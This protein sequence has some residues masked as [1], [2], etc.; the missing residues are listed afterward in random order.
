MLA[1][2]TAI[3]ILNI[4]PDW[5]VWMALTA[6]SFWDIVAV[7]TPCGPLK[8]LV[9][10][11]NRRGD[12]KFP[13]ILYNCK[14]HNKSPKYKKTIKAKTTVPGLIKNFKKSTSLV[15]RPTQK[16]QRVPLKCRFIFFFEKLNNFSKFIREWSGFPWHNTIK[17]YPANWIQQFIEFKAFGIWFTFEASSDSQT[18]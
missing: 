5:T 8:M 13:A 18:D 15:A 10:T 3:F 4:L 11:A 16:N 6:I 1:G 9:E 14:L 17:Q 2:L 12:D 7:L